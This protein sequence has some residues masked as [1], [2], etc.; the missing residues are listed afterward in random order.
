MI[1]DQK[2]TVLKMDKW[3]RLGCPF[4]FVISYDLEE[5]ILVP[6]DE[7]P[8]H[9]IH[10]SLNGSGD[11]NKA[12]KTPLQVEKI[13]LEHYTRAFETVQ[14]ALQAGNTFL[15]NLTASSTVTGPDL[16]AIY[17]G[18]NAPFKLW[19]EDRFVCFTPERFVKVNEQ[20]LLSTSPMKGTRPADTPDAALRLLQDEKELYE[21]TTIVDL[22]R[23]DL[24]Q[25][26]E[27]VRVER[28]RYIDRIRKADGTELLQMSS[29]IRG[30]LAQDWKSHL[31]SWFFRLLP[32][33]S[34][35][36]APKAQ[37]LKIIKEAEKNLHLNG[38]RG[39]YTGVAGVFDGQT[40][41]TFV[42]IRF[43]EKQGNNL[44]F[45]SGG[46]ITYRSLCAQEYAEIYQKVYLP[47]A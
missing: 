37:T 45:K 46:G 2:D 47:I 25:E 12:L 5:N 14:A 9:P 42:L 30:Q 18:V 31:G 34:I 28:F 36:G 24:S 6:L 27:E 4:L 15:L 19:L 38:E 8:S 20:G 26:A 16:Q 22:L 3:G 1:F 43:I 13:P 11:R 41:D 10:Y 35:C 40:L 29:E 17:E 33:G 44:V 21:H 32:A 39:Y 23:N 7:V